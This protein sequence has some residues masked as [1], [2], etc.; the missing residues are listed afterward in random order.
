MGVFRT[1]GG[2]KAAGGGKASSAVLGSKAAAQRPGRGGT[3][4]SKPAKAAIAEDIAAKKKGGDPDEVLVLKDRLA[5]GHRLNDAELAQLE[6]A[7]VAR[8]NQLQREDEEELERQR[9]IE[10]EKEQKREQKLQQELREL[11]HA[12][13]VDRANLERAGAA[14]ADELREL[15]ELRDEAAKDRDNLEAA[16]AQE[17][18]ELREL[19]DA[20]KAAAVARSAAS[21]D[22]DMIA[23]EA[24]YDT[25]D[26]QSAV[27]AAAARTPLAPR[28]GSFGLLPTLGVSAGAEA[29]DGEEEEGAVEDAQAGNEAAAG[30]DNDA[31]A[32]ESADGDEPARARRRH[33][34]AHAASSG[35]HAAKTRA[36]GKIM[37]AEKEGGGK[38]RASRP[39][40]PPLPKKRPPPKP[41]P[42]DDDDE[43]VDAEAALRMAAFQEY[44]REKALAAERAGEAA[45]SRAAL[46]DGWE[47][48]PRGV[49]ARYEKTAAAK[50]RAREAERARAAMDHEKRE[51]SGV[52]DMEY[53]QPG[54]PSEPRVEHG[55]AAAKTKV[56]FRSFGAYARAPDSPPKGGRRKLPPPP[57]PLG[58]ACADL[59]S[60]VGLTLVGATLVTRLY[61]CTPVDSPLGNVLHATPALELLER[62][63]AD[64]ERSLSGR[65][66]SLFG[67]DDAGGHTRGGHDGDGL[68]GRL[69]ALLSEDLG[70]Q[71]HAIRSDAQRFGERRQTHYVSQRTFA[72]P[73]L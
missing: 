19:R 20:Q 32:D 42:A 9:A 21:L 23:L 66:L 6:L 11:R 36:R 72:I 73:T 22:P 53:A 58:S 44:A 56:D 67:S 35:M 16:V 14:V 15:R 7:A 26:P 37:A 64:G 46:L 4:D 61:V 27:P 60:I 50:L 10:A 24:M 18:A 5:K 31:S 55:G 41:P 12:A 47:A 2:G 25:A 3:S 63:G 40:P 33:G 1:P 69:G 68:V 28:T 48:A 70:A 29:R 51:K 52:A 17:L 30:R 13:A 59:V 65:H 49:R 43:E 39:P 71:Y 34:G 54:K 62:L 57:R 8:W 38:E 45:P